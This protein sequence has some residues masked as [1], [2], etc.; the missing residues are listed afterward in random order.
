[1]RR[2]GVFT[3]RT[4]AS[5]WLIVVVGLG[6]GSDFIANDRPLAV[7]VDGRT[8]FP[9]LAEALTGRSQPSVAVPVTAPT[10]AW[11][12]WPPIPYNGSDSDL[13]V[14]AYT[15]PFA[16]DQIGP[17]GVHLL[18]TD[19]LGRDV[20]AALVRG[21]GVATRVGIGATLIALL[22][23][24]TLGG[25]AGFFGN[26]GLQNSRAGYIAAVVGGGA[27]AGYGFLCLVPFFGVTGAGATMIITLVI[28]ILLAGVIYLLLRRFA[29]FR[30][31]VDLPA[32]TF[33]LQLVEVF[34][35]IP[36]L[37]LLIAATALI[38]TPSVWT[39][40]IIIGL[41]G[42]PQVVRYLRAELIRIRALPY[43]EAAYGSGV[44]RWRILWRHALPNAL[45]P[46]VVLAA[47]M[48]GGAILLEAFLSFLGLGLPLN[49]PTWGGLLRRARERP[50]AWWLALFPGLLLT[51][52]VL[53]LQV[54]VD[55]QGWAR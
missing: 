8:Y 2:R 27:G 48:V 53:A 32:D 51:F 46:I 40:V 49:D 50:E 30:H 15:P 43:I 7:R 24:I 54:L 20:A 18:G 47:F 11:V 9:A 41:L 37:V 12:I 14:T 23:G 33:T 38:A 21:A 28:G 1:M 13:S 22:I 5:L 44:G 4:A 39:I 52:T 3:I 35:G 45:G 31:R 36:G 34:T 55:R 19:A 29:F 25:I 10:T 26:N 16:Y 42:W 17:R 6:L